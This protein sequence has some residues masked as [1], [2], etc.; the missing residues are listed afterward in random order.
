MKRMY[1][2]TL[3][4]F[5]QMIH[6]QV[7]YKF[8]KNTSA[9]EWRIIDDGVMGGLSQGRFY[10]NEEGFGVFTGDVSLKNYGGFS[11]VRYSSPAPFAT[12][13]ESK[14]KLRIKGDGKNYQLRIKDKASTYYSYIYT[15]STS[16]NWETIVL[17]LKDFYPSFRGQT[18]KLP[19]YAASSFEEIVFLIANKKEETFKLE[20]KEIALE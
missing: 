9:K 2:F 8:S 5:S 10:I 18:L 7:L 17:P 16:G 20:I 11:S 1:L 6:S 4:F 14:I 12:T 15:F 19:N 13:R 3:L